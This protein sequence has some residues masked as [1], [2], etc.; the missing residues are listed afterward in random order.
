MAVGPEHPGPSQPLPAIPLPVAPIN[1]EQASNTDAPPPPSLH[2]PLPNVTPLNPLRET[3]IPIDP[4]LLDY[5]KPRSVVT[6]SPGREMREE[7]PLPRRWPRVAASPE[8]TPP[9]TQHTPPPTQHTLPLM[10]HTPP[11]TQHTP[12][13]PLANATPPSMGVTV[14]SASGTSTSD[15]PKHLADAY[16]YLTEE[17]VWTKDGTV[18]NARRWGKAWLGCL[19]SFIEFQ[20]QAGFPDAGPCFP[21]STDIRPREIGVWMKNGRR[22]KDVEIIDIERFSRQWWGWWYSLQ[23]KSRIR[24]DKGDLT[25]PTPDMDWSDLRKPGKNGFLLIVI[26]LAWWGKVSNQDGNW[27]KAVKDVTE[28]LSCIQRASSGAP[29]VNPLQGSSNANAAG[30]IRSKRSRGGDSAA[31]EGSSRKKRKV[32]S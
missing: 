23:P 18:T 5:F 21:P 2:T 24:D 10:Q 3:S 11:P 13:M 28:V 31:V 25:S 19:Q 20:R 17:T 26:S 9:P 14:H 8:P 12:P 6:P 16:Q 32:R 27:T 7:S 1:V 15:L 30:S 22:W 29:K 4:E